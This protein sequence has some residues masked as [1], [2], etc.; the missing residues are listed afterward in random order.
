MSGMRMLHFSKDWRKFT[1]IHQHYTMALNDFHP[2]GCILLLAD[3]QPLFPRP[4]GAPQGPRN[5]QGPGRP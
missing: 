1:H 4:S 5:P 2:P 3:V